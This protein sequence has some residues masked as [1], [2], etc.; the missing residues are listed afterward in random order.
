MATKVWVR[1]YPAQHHT[2]MHYASPNTYA[3]TSNSDAGHWQERHQR[4][5]NVGMT[6]LCGSREGC[7]TIVVGRVDRNAG[8][9]RLQ[10]DVHSN[11]VRM[12]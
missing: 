5:N 7:T 2:D 8:S 1:P 9:N 4:L 12:G 11:A 10:V 6:V 3:C